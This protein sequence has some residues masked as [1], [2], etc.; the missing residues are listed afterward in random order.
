MMVA[1]QCGDTPA[2]AKSTSKHRVTYPHRND[3]RRQDSQ[4]LKRS[5]RVERGRTGILG[6]PHPKSQRVEM[7]RTVA[8][9]KYPLFSLSRTDGYSLRE[10]SRQGLSKP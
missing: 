10:N 1:M 7:I 5:I 8:E 6:T 9:P 4:R 2:L 3:L